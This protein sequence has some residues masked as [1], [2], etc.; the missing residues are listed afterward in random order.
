MLKQ[1]DELLCCLLYCIDI[2]QSRR[3]YNPRKENINMSRNMPEND[4][5]MYEFDSGNL[6]AIET[7]S[8]LNTPHPYVMIWFNRS[9]RK[10]DSGLA[11]TKTEF[12]KH[13]DCTNLYCAKFNCWVSDEH[14]F[15]RADYQGAISQM[16]ISHHNQC[17]VAG[18]AYPDEMIEAPNFNPTLFRNRAGGG[19]L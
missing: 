11:F 4:R 19:R 18:D 13:P 5:I 14:K 15:L 12:A 1:V 2:H 9:V 3:M 8:A 7:K 17:C 16:V 10:D 6:S